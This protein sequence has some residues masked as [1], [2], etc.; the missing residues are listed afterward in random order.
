M[1][2]QSC[3][4]HG[5]ALKRRLAFACQ[6]ECVL[7]CACIS[8]PH[9]LH[10]G[11]CCNVACNLRL[12]LHSLPYHFYIFFSVQRQNVAFQPQQ[13]KQQREYN[14]NIYVCVCVCFAFA[15]HFR[16]ATIII[17]VCWFVVLWFVVH[18]NA[19][20]NVCPYTYM[21]GCDCVCLSI[22]YFCWQK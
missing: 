10:G 15:M 16:G 4:Q 22:Q 9:T 18:G 19:C 3:K 1:P 17:F 21:C 8:F 12:L 20:N 13:Q 7:V 14:L 6:F 2:W 11:H 5:T